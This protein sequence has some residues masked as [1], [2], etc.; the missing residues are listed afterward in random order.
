MTGMPLGMRIKRRRQA[1]GMD[2]KDLAERIGV[3]R[4][5]V[6]NW[7]SGKHFPL[8]HLGAVEQVLGIDLTGGPDTDPLP[9]R[10]RQL[11]EDEIPEDRRAEVEERSTLSRDV[12]RMRRQGWLDDVPGAD[13]RT[14]LLRITPAGRRL[15]EE[16]IPA[17][18]QAQAQ[19][20]TLLGESQV[21]TLSQ[22]ATTLRKK[23]PSIRT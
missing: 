15:V 1:L 9:R 10:V 2:Q 11:I 19:A 7:E 12:V 14:V 21:S 16:A 8:R 3:S 4:A 17:W 22:A 23:R 13:G 6:A 20:T 5:T 18:Q